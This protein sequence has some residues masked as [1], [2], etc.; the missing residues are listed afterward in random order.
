MARLNVDV[1]A[2]VC[3][4]ILQKLLGRQKHYQQQLLYRQTDREQENFIPIS[5]LSVVD[6][7]SFFLMYR[8]Y[9]LSSTM[10][11]WSPNEWMDEFEIKINMLGLILSIEQVNNNNK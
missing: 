11:L 5:L 9:I 8:Y 7:V 10:Y 2:K 6:G 3:I 1:G 4:S